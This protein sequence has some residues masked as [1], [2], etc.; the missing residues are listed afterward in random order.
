[1]S[2]AVLLLPVFATLK[3]EVHTQRKTGSNADGDRCHGPTV[4]EMG[5]VLNKT[6]GL[7]GSA[8]GFIP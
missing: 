6:G 3:S 5:T 2:I 7:V 4:K 1:M 8:F